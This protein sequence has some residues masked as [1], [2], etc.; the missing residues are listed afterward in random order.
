MG[1]TKIPKLFFSSRLPKHKPLV[2]WFDKTFLKI[3]WLAYHS[4]LQIKQTSSSVK[5]P[6]DLISV[7]N[8]FTLLLPTTL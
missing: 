2:P 7:T 8:V 3:G 6:L 1:Y 4:A 5:R